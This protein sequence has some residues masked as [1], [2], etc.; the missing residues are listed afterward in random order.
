MF[1]LSLFLLG[2]EDPDAQADISALQDSLDT[3]QT[4]MQT[5]AQTITELEQENTDLKARL[6]AME[7]KND[8]QDSAI[9]Q[10]EL[11]DE[12]Q[13]G[14][15]EILFERVDNHDEDIV[16]LDADVL[17]QGSAITTV[18]GRVDD[19]VAETDDLFAYL[20]VDTSSDEVVFSGANVFVQSGAGSTDATV[21][22]LGNL[23][24]GYNEGTPS[25]QTGSHNL[26]VGFG[27]AYSSYGGAVFGYYNT[28][29]APGATLLGGSTNAVSGNYSV[30]VGGYANTVT[31]GGSV[32][33]GG[34]S[35]TVTD[36]YSYAP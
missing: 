20:S 33:Y 25:S 5:Q 4:Q 36:D 26:I 7:S 12:V 21:N 9:G 32:V 30:I 3:L 14:E 18:E 2:C 29:T 24:V 17:S 19:V 28:S 10:I 34:Q 6:D 13:E 35:Q 15:L 11:L 8:S 1:L 27:H 16:A 31:G 22:G 23:I